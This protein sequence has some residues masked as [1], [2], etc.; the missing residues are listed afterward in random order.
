MKHGAL[1]GSVL[2]VIATVG[3]STRAASIHRIGD[4]SAYVVDYL[5][6]RRGAYLRP[7]PADPNSRERWMICAEP[8]PDVAV[9][10]TTDIAA[11]LK[12]A[13]QVDASGTAKVS[14]AIVDLAK[15]GQTLQLQREALYRLCELQVNGSLTREDAIALYTKVLESIQAIAFAELGDSALPEAAKKTFLE[16]IQKNYIPKPDAK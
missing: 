16:S 11:A 15:R 2:V 4:S 9:A 5:A 6:S 3:C 10:M 8:A 7:I 1:A 13:A 14:E 12:Q